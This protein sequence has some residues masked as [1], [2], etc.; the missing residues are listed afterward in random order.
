MMVVRFTL[1]LCVLLASSIAYAAT[2]CT[3]YQ[4]NQPLYNVCLHDQEVAKQAQQGATS[5][6]Q[7]NC[8]AYAGNQGLYN[9]CLQNQETAIKAQNLPP[10]PG[11]GSAPITQQPAVTTPP[12]ASAKQ[13]P[14]ASSPTTTSPNQPS[15]QQRSPRIQYY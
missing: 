4:E 7:S 11:K 6:P 10:N 8:A 13:A 1:L 14:E 3:R 15:Q 12:P 9:T 5:S 2:D